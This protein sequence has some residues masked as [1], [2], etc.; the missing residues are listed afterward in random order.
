MTSRNLAGERQSI[1]GEKRS[2]RYHG[3]RYDEKEDDDD[4]EERRYENL[5]DT[6]KINAIKASLRRAQN[7]DDGGLALVEKRFTKWID[8]GYTPYNLP[9]ALNAKEY[10]QLRQKFYSWKYHNHL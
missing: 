7:G 9:S 6:K 2:L 5:F 4:D 10:N 8:Q 1:G 3:E